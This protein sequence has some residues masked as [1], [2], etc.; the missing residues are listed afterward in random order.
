MTREV[1]EFVEICAKE[2]KADSSLYTWRDENYIGLR[3]GLGNDCIK[4]FEIG[5]E[6]GFFE[7]WFVNEEE[8]MFPDLGEYLYLGINLDEF[9]EV[10]FK[11][12]QRLAI[13]N[14]KKEFT[15]YGTLGIVS[16]KRYEFHI[17]EGCFI[18]KGFSLYSD[19]GV[20]LAYDSLDRDMRVS[21]DDILTFKARFS[22]CAK[23]NTR[24]K[25]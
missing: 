15:N 24:I 7:N 25:R 10:N 4:V 23:W 12:Y 3:Y 21:G 17:G 20:F 5:N 6:V 11:G 13:K 9:T 2:F 14:S 1:L 19:R 18:A 16:N 8:K 22:D